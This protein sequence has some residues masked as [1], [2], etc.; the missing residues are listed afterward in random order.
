MYTITSGEREN[1][2]SSP[3][4]LGAEGLLGSE[5]MDGIE[6]ATEPLGGA[7]AP[8]SEIQ[9]LFQSIIETIGYLFRL[10]VLI[11]NS[12]SRDRYSKALAMASKMPFDDHFDID[13][14]GNKFPRL[15]QDG[16][17]WLRER[18]GKAITQR[19]QYLRYCRE[20]R[21][22]L[23]RITEAP[24]SVKFSPEQNTTDIFL[25]DQQPR[26]EGD[27]QTVISNTRSTLAPTTAST[28][29]PV[30]L[31]N[32]DT[33]ETPEGQDDGDSQSQISYAT[34]VGESNSDNRLT[35][36]RLEEVARV[37]QLFECPY[38]WT[39]QKFSHQHGWR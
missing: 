18:L 14:V 24:S 3:V 31:E 6:A 29:N 30:K 10:S 1:R 4:Q 35:V 34:S 11:R 9:E 16:M 8:I 7:H 2:V 32:S 37:G 36:I 33:M 20:H 17:A 38:C 28:V 39:I 12:S 15:R 25:Q 22:R 26:I 13:H 27:T 5:E 19:R 23:S 21:E